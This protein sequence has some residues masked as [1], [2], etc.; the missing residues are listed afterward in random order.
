MPSESVDE[1]QKHAGHSTMSFDYVG[2]G[3]PLYSPLGESRKPLRSTWTGRTTRS[4]KVTPRVI[5]LEEELRNE[6]VSIPEVVSNVNFSSCSAIDAEDVSEKSGISLPSIKW[7]T[8]NE[9]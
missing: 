3:T 1:L 8:G 7:E 5:A 6:K 4:N 2:V 9:T